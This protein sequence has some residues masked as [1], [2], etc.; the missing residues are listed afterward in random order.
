[1]SKPRPRK[2]D[3]DKD[4]PF[5]IRLPRDMRKRLARLASKRR[6]K[7]SS[8]ARMLLE[9]AMDRDEAKMKDTL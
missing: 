8:Y 7:D 4:V 2:P 5:S 6:L 3:P 9:E 1:M